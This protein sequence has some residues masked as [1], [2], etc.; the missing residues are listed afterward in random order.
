MNENHLETLSIFFSLTVIL[1]T[2]FI[3]Q[4]FIL[5]LIW[6]A[7]IAIATWSIY[8]KWRALLGERTL[9]AASTLILF[10]MLIVALPLLWFTAVITNELQIFT[11][12]LIHANATGITSPGWLDQLPY[13]GANLKSLWMQTLG[14]PQGIA[15]LLSTHSQFSLKP[16]TSILKTFGSQVAHRSVIFLFTLLCLFFFYKDG[17]VLIKQ[18]NAMGRYFLKDRWERYSVNLPNAIRATVNGLV[19]VGIAIGVIMGIFYAA[20]GIPAPALLGTVT[21]ISA[22]IPFAIIIAFAVAA[23]LLI[24]QG[25]LILSLVMVIFGS[26]IMFVADHFIRPSIIGGATQ[27]PFL[28][29]LFG[30]LGGVNVFG[31]VGLFIGPIIMVLFVTLWNEVDLFKKERIIREG[32]MS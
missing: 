26:V 28:A 25:K 22:I 10:I 17:P 18:V 31:L 2:G 32:G 14:K 1:L 3:L 30:I 4:E 15:N 5:P 16:L 8:T 21:A 19:L 23:L 11:K 6:A 7:I 9:L 20:V 27:L 12:Y 13:V 24:I 29:V